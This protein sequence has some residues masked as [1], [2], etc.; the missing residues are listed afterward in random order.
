MS[1]DDRDRTERRTRPSLSVRRFEPDDTPAIQHLH[2]LAFEELPTDPDDIPGTED[3]QD[4]EGSYLD[5]G[6]EF[7]VGVLSPTAVEASL[8]LSS[9]DDRLRVDDGY[10]VAMGGY[11]PS[12]AGYDDERSI[13]GGAE[14]HRMRVAPAV[15]RLGYGRELLAA[16]ERRIEAAGFDPILATTARR[17]AAAVAFY[18]S[19]GYEIV[20]ESTSGPY[21][22]VHFEKWLSD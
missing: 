22:L 15:Q 10:L 6:G 21:R 4:V 19:E 18:R 5:V 8:E 20:D 7:L 13:E 12:A 16:L 14:L 9:I 2:E 3:L 1:E 17:Q 11:L